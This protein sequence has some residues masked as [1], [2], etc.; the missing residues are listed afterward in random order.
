[1][2]VKISSNHTAFLHVDIDSPVTL[3]RFWGCAPAEDEVRLLD[4]FYNIAMSRAL[5]FFEE[6]SVPA[7]FFCVGHELQRSG[8][9]SKWIKKAFDSGHEIANHTHSHSFKFG[10]LLPEARRS[11]IS[12]CS[13][14]IERLIGRKPLGF[15]APSY[16][17]TSDLIDLLESMDFQYDC[18]AFFSSLNFLLDLYHRSR[19]K[20]D[21]EN[22]FKGSM[23]APP[24]NAYFPSR[25]NFYSIGE[26]R[27]VM[28][29]PM[30]RNGFFN[31]PFYNNFHL[32]AGE[33]YRKID[34]YMM[35]QRH[36]PYLFHL[37]EFCDL[38]DPI[39]RSL[40]VHPNVS[41]SAIKKINAMRDSI[42][43][44]KKRYRI[45]RTDNFVLRMKSGEE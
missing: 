31:F 42:A 43:I 30:P 14:V 8:A 19:R 23:A 34:L 5:D 44:L 16:Q 26:P 41:I 18:S 39:P 7:T 28:E 1:M 40:K 11:E 9:A 13:E 6:N 32:S 24:A 38:S 33:L 27:R 10:A 15:R 36:L 22:G 21:A 12:Q 35:R 2:N 3:L 20:S 37:I 45:M 25:K 29:I 4:R 17:V